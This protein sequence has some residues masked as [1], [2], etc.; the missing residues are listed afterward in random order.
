MNA[1][2]SMQI[3]SL[4]HHVQGMPCEAMHAE[5]SLWVSHQGESSIW[6][7]L[8]GQ[9]SFLG[10]NIR[11]AHLVDILQRMHSVIRLLYGSVQRLINLVRPGIVPHLSIA[12][13]GIKDGIS[14]TCQSVSHI[15]TGK[16]QWQT[17]CICCTQEERKRLDCWRCSGLGMCD[18]VAGQSRALPTSLEDCFRT[19]MPFMCRENSV[20]CRMPLGLQRGRS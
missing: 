4:S 14:S 18:C 3:I 2:P 10:P 12:M 8:V 9:R 16:R 13:T 17:P 20:L 19:C 6:L 5:N 7:L 1:L 11:D 15:V